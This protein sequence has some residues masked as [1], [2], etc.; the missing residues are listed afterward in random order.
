MISPVHD[1]SNFLLPSPHQNQLWL[2]VCNVC[3]RELELRVQFDCMCLM[4]ELLNS[5]PSNID[6]IEAAVDKLIDAFNTINVSMDEPIAFEKEIEFLCTH[7]LPLLRNAGKIEP[8]LK[9]KIGWAVLFEFCVE[10]D[11]L[12]SAL[13]ILNCGLYDNPSVFLLAIKVNQPK[14]LQL[15]HKRFSPPNFVFRNGDSPI[16]VAINYGHISL[17]K[18]L[19]KLGYSFTI[20]NKWS[21]KTT[22][23][24]FIESIM[25]DINKITLL[26][27]LS[28]TRKD[29]DFKVPDE[30]GCT[31]YH[32]AAKA[33]N[34]AVL[35][36]ARGRGI[37]INQKNNNGETALFELLKLGMYQFDIFKSL[38]SMVTEF[39]DQGALPSIG[40]GS[41]D[42]DCYDLVWESKILLEKDKEMIFQEFL[43]SG[44]TPSAFNIREFKTILPLP[45]VPEASQALAR[46][47]K[48]L[49]TSKGFKREIHDKQNIEHGFVG[50]VQGTQEM[51]RLVCNLSPLIF[52][53]SSLIQHK[54]INPNLYNAFLIK[55]IGHAFGLP[56]TEKQRTD[57]LICFE[58]FSEA[59]AMPMLASTI[60]VMQ[61]KLLSQIDL[62][63]IFD[64]L[65]TA[66]I[67]DRMSAQDYD[68]LSAELQVPNY[69]D[70]KVCG[71]GFDWHFPSWCVYGDYL[72]YCNRG[73]DSLSSCEIAVYRMDEKDRS[74]MT[75]ETLKKIIDRYLSNDANYFTQQEMETTFNL[76]KIYGL[77]LKQQKAGNCTYASSKAIIFVLMAIRYLM[78]RYSENLPNEWI[79][80]KE[81]FIH[82]KP[83]Y[84]DFTELDRIV[85][86]THLIQEVDEFLN[87]PLNEKLEEG[88]LYYTLLLTLVASFSNPGMLLQTSL[89]KRLD[90]TYR[91]ALW[92]R[93][94]KIFPYIRHTL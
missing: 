56:K 69:T 39:I 29:L 32:F 40:N 94:I 79:S 47:T 7:F 12:Y 41:E 30:A 8:N 80:W 16:Y 45:I 74:K 51:R 20:Q 48:I 14:K 43:K 73:Y 52:S 63:W 86:A 59:F 17:I 9:L 27:F 54:M 5:S 18:L 26:N 76:H 10:K 33:K 15:L 42:Q 81:A 21:K 70:A 77:P 35:Q 46:D 1:F 50:E 44:C 68:K 87:N 4:K 66:H 23:Q 24:C 78:N 53:P 34:L 75:P 89:I 90:Y 65:T 36:W 2:W 19:S 88:K 31:I 93:L 37:P 92:E 38:S 55:R 3:S 6:E 85:V 13:S 11:F 61:P 22:L 84:K 91:I 62:D 83:A 57:S 28:D 72:F 82:L 25:L 58:G 67:G 71:C 60:K 49:L 64:K